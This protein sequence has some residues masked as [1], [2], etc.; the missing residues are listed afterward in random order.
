MDIYFYYADE[1][2]IDYLKKV[3]KSTR[4]FTCVPNTNYNNAKKFLFGAVMNV[5]GHNYY[6]PVS[7]YSKDQQDVIL[8]KDKKTSQILGSL[9][10]AYMLPIPAECCKK[11]NINTFNSQAAAH[12]SKEL[13]FCRRNRDKIFKQAEKTYNRVINKVDEMLVKNSCDFKTL[14]RACQKFRE[15]HNLD[16]K[17]ETQKPLECKTKP[18]KPKL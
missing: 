4:G 1:E 7:S 3:E 9:R 5:N 11:V 15:F 12:I 8:I 17:T 2:Y 6:V 10:F 16:S 13:A 18:P 14:E